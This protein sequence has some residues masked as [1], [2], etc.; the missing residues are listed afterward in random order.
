MRKL[1]LA[2]F[3]ACIDTL[4]HAYNFS[5]VNS[6]GVTIY[7][8]ILSSVD[9]T[10]EVTYR[11][12]SYNSYSGSVVIPSTVNNNDKEY[13]VT[14][15]G[16]EAFYICKNLTDIT[17]PNS[18]T[19]IGTY[20]FYGCSGLTSISIPNSMT[21]IEDYA[22]GDCSSLIAIK[23]PESIK[24]IEKQV[25]QGCSNLE[26]ISLPNSLVNIKDH[27]FWYCDKLTSLVI[28]YSV[29]YISK[30]AFSYCPNIRNVTVFSE[31]PPI[32]NGEGTTVANSMFDSATFSYGKLNVPAS[33][34]NAYISISPWNKFNVINKIDNDS[35]NKCS[36]PEITFSDKT[37]SFSCATPQSQIHYSYYLGNMGSTES[38]GELV[39]L[40]NKSNSIIVMAY[41]TAEGY[42]QSAAVI[43][44]FPFDAT[45]NDINGDNKITIAD[46]TSLIDIIVNQ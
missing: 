8:N 3:L 12:T 26:N 18:V 10:C 30:S 2:L 20:A 15:I 34:Y 13:S 7:Y 23:L 38:G 29:K 36:A 40:T 24:T 44:S 31:R 16:K 14:K 27:A 5:A 33:A 19:N 11:T 32:M 21:S 1:L 4:V 22:F 43:K 25:F 42:E 17:I 41:A 46:V 6:D 45:V 37:L 28:P 39:T 35:Y 9:L